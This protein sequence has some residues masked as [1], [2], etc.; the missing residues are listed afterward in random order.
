MLLSS[1]TYHL[2]ENPF[3][4]DKKNSDFKFIKNI[5]V[6]LILFLIQISAVKN[7]YINNYFDYFNLNVSPWEDLKNDKGE[8]CYAN[9]K[10]FCEFNGTSSQKI[11][12]VGDSIMGSLQTDL[13]ERLSKLDFQTIIMTSND[14]FF[15]PNFNYIYKKNLNEHQR[16][17]YKY[18]RKR[19]SILQRLKIQLLY[20][21]KYTCVFIK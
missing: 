12:I 9:Q 19:Y 14:C 20:R 18:Q 17:S 5:A 10:F 7:Y 2:V 16:C 11:Y 4:R 1:I 8:T 3:W 13:T 15:A 21:W 6:V